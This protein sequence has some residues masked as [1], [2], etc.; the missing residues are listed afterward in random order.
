MSL[1]H[2]RTTVAWPK[3]AAR[4]GDGAP[5]GPSLD[6]LR[7]WVGLRRVFD[8]PIG[9]LVASP[10]SLLSTIAASFCGA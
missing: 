3:E 9:G 7:A 1:L 2:P 6:R 4:M 8:D 5:R 10:R